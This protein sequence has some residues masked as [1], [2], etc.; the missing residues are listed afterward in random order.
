MYRGWCWELNWYLHLAWVGVIWK[1][2]GPILIYYIEVLSEFMANLQYRISKQLDTGVLW[3]RHSLNEPHNFR[4]CV[5]NCTYKDSRWP[6]IHEIFSC[7]N[8]S[9]HLTNWHNALYVFTILYNYIS[10]Y[11]HSFCQYTILFWIVITCVWQK[12]LRY[13]SIIYLLTWSL[14][15]L[16][17]YVLITHPHTYSLIYFLSYLLTNLHFYSLT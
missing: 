10:D 8:L 12:N 13:Y 6:I 4:P 3:Q 11:I 7:H 9:F 14:N 16:V 1:T 15:N 17:N 2:Q 5:H